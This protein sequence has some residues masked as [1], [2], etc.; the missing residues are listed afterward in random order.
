MISEI[1][2]RSVIL[3]PIQ[4]ASRR[5]GKGSD[6]KSVPL[7]LNKIVYAF[8]YIENRIGTFGMRG[9]TI[10]VLGRKD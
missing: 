4:I 5:F 3:K 8:S 6:L 9:M 1:Y 2:S 7:L 10:W